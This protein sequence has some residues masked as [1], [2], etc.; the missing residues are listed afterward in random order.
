MRRRKLFLYGALTLLVMALIFF[1]SSRDGTE[2]GG[3][4]AWLLQTAPGRF[5]IRLLPRLTEQGPELDIRKYAHMG[6]FALLA[7]PSALFFRELRRPGPLA[8]AILES[9]FFCVFY[10]CTD[11]YHQTFVPGRAGTAKDVLVDLV[12]ILFGLTIVL[13]IC[14]KELK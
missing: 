11:E 10:A 4:S 3:M 14:R 5:L 13:V 1:M 12:G 8:A 2:S 9:L 7:V 6:E